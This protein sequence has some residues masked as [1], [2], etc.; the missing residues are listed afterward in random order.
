MGTINSRMGRP[1]YRTWFSVETIETGYRGIL[2]PEHQPALAGN[3]IPYAINCMIVTQLS[4][5]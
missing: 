4:G 2:Q 5:E 1:N 3:V